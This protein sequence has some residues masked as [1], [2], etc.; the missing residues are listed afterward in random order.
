MSET[1]YYFNH[2]TKHQLDKRLQ[3]AI[4]SGDT[5]TARQ[6]ITVYGVKPAPW[7]LAKAS[8]AGHPDELIRLI[9]SNLSK[10]HR[11]ELRI[12]WVEDVIKERRLDILR[13]WHRLGVFADVKPSYKVKMLTTNDIVFE[14]C[15]DGRYEMLDYFILELKFPI[16]YDAESE[17]KYPYRNSVFSWTCPEH[18]ASHILSVVSDLPLQARLDALNL[19]AKYANVPKCRELASSPEIS[20]DRLTWLLGRAVNSGRADFVEMVLRDL[21]R[22]VRFLKFTH[23]LQSIMIAIGMRR[24]VDL[25]RLLLDYHC[26]VPLKQCAFECI[27][28]EFPE[29]LRL[30]VEKGV[31]LEPDMLLFAC[32]RE[33]V[34]MVCTL[35]ELGA[36]PDATTWWGRLVCRRPDTVCNKNPAI[37][38]LLQ[39]YSERKIRS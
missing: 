28:L 35:L 5:A 10:F 37:L 2:L 3:E 27:D 18:V 17:P 25:L 14:S 7:D 32:A 29:G 38:N 34:L 13:Q 30:L 21:G 15:E 9:V 19:M 20:S 24:L 16:C 31:A 22:P 12:T 11:E 33:Y 8:L 4:V 26:I 6:L 36:N 39:E 1:R 23:A